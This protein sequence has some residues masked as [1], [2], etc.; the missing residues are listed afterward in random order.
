[1]KMDGK[2]NLSKIHANK[3]NLFFF[4]NFYKIPLESYHE[5][6]KKVITNRESLDTS[7]INDLYF[8]GHSLGDKFRY[9]RICYNVFIVGIFSCVIAFLISYF[10]MQ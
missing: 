8:L 2:T 3:T 4:G 1:M 5:A 6:I 9:L 10:L 7:I